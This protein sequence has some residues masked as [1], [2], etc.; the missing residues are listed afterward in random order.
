MTEEALDKTHTHSQTSEKIQAKKQLL[1]DYFSS[2]SKRLS[3]IGLL[4][5]LVLTVH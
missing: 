4:R 3:V 5:P 1:S 2:L